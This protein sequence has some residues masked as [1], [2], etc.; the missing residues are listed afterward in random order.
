MPASQ[1][2][3]GT[4]E[5]PDVLAVDKR[6]GGWEAVPLALI[7]DPR[8]EL[9]T[10]AL[11]IWLVTKPKPWKIRVQKLPDLLK[12]SKACI[13]IGRGRVR[14]MLGE[15]ERAGYLTRSKYRRK[16]GV[17]GWRS[18]LSPISLT[19]GR[20]ATGGS[21]TGGAATGGR[22][23]A[24]LQT[25]K[26]SDSKQISDSENLRAKSDAEKA[27]L[28]KPARSKSQRPIAAGELAQALLRKLQ[29]RSEVPAKLAATLADPVV[30]SAPSRPVD[31]RYRSQNR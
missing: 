17:W 16:G 9:D 3:Q 19:R 28:I 22:P 23:P 2:R 5:P 10:T 6:R 15:L 8:L 18:V 11:A 1:A 30:T 4:D 12:S 26:I 21:P 7:R 25:P 13:R 14:R 31:G 29:D 20:S 27:G 24:Y